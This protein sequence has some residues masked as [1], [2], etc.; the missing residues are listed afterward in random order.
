M[1][2]A[3][4]LLNQALQHQ[5]QV[6]SLHAPGGETC[7]A[8]AS[9]R[10]MEIARILEGWRGHYLDRGYVAIVW[11]YGIPTASFTA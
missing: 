11:R 8:F 1:N 4:A 6:I 3:A 10:C 9:Q 7:A 5:P 2:E